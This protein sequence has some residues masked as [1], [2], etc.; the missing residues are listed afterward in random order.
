M[1]RISCTN[2]TV[3]AKALRPTQARSQEQE[4]VSG[5][6]HGKVE[7]TVQEEAGETAG[8]SHLRFLECLDFIRQVFK[9]IFCSFFTWRKREG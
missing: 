8:A 9:N 5:W 4:E 3:S 2:G 6:T 1:E 7:R